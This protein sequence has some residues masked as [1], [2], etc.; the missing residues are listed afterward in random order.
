MGEGL[1]FDSPEN[2]I[3]I[4]D[5]KRSTETKEVMRQRKIQFS[6]NHMQVGPDEYF[7]FKKKN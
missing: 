2:K 3:E 4:W 5:D 6:V 1:N 7:S